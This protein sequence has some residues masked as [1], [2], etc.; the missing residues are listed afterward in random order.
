[1]VFNSFFAFLDSLNLYNWIDIVVVIFAI[2][3]A[4]YGIMH[5]ITGGISKLVAYLTTFGIGLWVYNLI[6]AS[7]L[8]QNTYPNRIGAFVIAGIAGLIVGVCVGLLVAKCLRLIVSQPYDSIIGIFA[9]LA[10]YVVI[11]LGIFFL[12]KLTPMN[13]TTLRKKTISGMMGYAILDGVM[14]ESDQ[15]EIS[16]K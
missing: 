10:C 5:G 6:R 11:L 9:S 12:L 8:I 2:T 14:A 13:T 7:W 4:I 16:S 1:M 15:A 3:F